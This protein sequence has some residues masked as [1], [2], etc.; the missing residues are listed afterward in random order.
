MCFVAWRSSSVLCSINDV[1]LSQAQ[2]EPRWVT[3][4]SQVN[5]F[6]IYVICHSVDSAFYYLWNGK[7]SIK[8]R[9]PC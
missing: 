9:A 4:C 3:V 8:F 7:M 6:C 1:T 5:H 2:L